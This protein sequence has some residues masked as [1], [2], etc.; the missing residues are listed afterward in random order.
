MSTHNALDSDAEMSQ[1]DEGFR[2]SSALPLTASIFL[3][4]GFIRVCLDLP[5]ITLGRSVMCINS[6]TKCIE[7]G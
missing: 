4:E 7:I 1:I 6:F 3:V 2:I 5:G